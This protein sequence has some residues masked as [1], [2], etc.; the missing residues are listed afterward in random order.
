[1]PVH[2]FVIESV[3]E[4]A[5]G[6]DS[7]EAMIPIVRTYFQMFQPTGD[8][9]ERLKCR[10]IEDL[11]R[12]T[13]EFVE[14]AGNRPR[15]DPKWLWMSLHGRKPHLPEHLGTRGIAVCED[16]SG[17][18]PAS[19]EDFDWH[20][21]FGSLNTS[22]IANVIIVMDV[23]WGGS[24]SAPARASGR[25]GGPSFLFGPMRSAHR[26][27]L[28]TATALLTS[29]MRNGSLPSVEKAKE[30]VSVLNSF[31][32]TDPDSGMEFYRVWWWEDGH[33]QCFPPPS[34]RIKRVSP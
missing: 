30:I 26:L 17:M 11:L 28:N 22:S 20:K 6:G 18:S 33:S 29:V 5:L 13:E 23:C 32:P 3:P 8:I 16:S 2:M 14:W 12:A 19:N 15:D 27:E 1:M 10:G 4:S 31:F 25:S 9:R 21:I 24:P 7:I 34:G